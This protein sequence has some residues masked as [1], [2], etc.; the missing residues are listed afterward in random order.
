MEN[1]R[2]KSLFLKAT[3]LRHVG[4]N[5]QY[6]RYSVSL[7]IV[8]VTGCF[9]RGVRWLTVCLIDRQTSTECTAS[10]GVSGAQ[11]TVYEAICSKTGGS[12]PRGDLVLT[13]LPRG[14]TSTPSLCQ[15]P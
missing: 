1:I 9:L 7:A 10:G 8:S 14:I 12:R 5:T 3:Q 13:L 11:R 15:R 2:T 6:Y 4:A